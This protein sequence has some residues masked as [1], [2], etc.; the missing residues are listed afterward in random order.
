MADKSRGSTP[1]PQGYTGYTGVRG[2]G[3]DS[4]RGYPGHQGY[5]GVTITTS[6]PMARRR[7]VVSMTGAVKPRPSLKGRVSTLLT[8][9]AVWLGWSTSESA[10]V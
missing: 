4:R 6:T 7:V 2:S 10:E 1:Y 9:L 8:K 3:S 5:Q